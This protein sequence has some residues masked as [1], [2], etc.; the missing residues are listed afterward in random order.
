MPVGCI[1]MCIYAGDDFVLWLGEPFISNI[2][3]PDAA[4]EHVHVLGID[5]KLYKRLPGYPTTVR[6]PI[7]TSMQVS[8]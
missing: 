3:F 8:I 6:A 7:L 5:H 4:G 1:W 2:A